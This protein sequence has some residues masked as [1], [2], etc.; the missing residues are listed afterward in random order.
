MNP[1]Q[2][3][4]PPA[5]AFL[6]IRIK[7]TKKLLG[8]SKEDLRLVIKEYKELENIGTSGPWTDRNQG[9]ADVSGFVKTVLSSVL[10]IYFLVCEED[11]KKNYKIKLAIKRMYTAV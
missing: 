11:E 2:G 1:S 7:M 9:S 3:G 5:E 4:P 6:A 10:K 8:D